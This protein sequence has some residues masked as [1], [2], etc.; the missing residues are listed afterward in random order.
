MAM[1]VSV[2]RVWG[3]EGESQASERDLPGTRRVR[4]RNDGAG[5]RTLGSLALCYLRVQRNQDLTGVEAS[6]ALNG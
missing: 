5:G 4:P 6:T 1:N 2:L 3:A